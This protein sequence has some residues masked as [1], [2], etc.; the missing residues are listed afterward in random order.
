MDH[1]EKAAV[2]FLNGFNCAQSVLAAF[3]PELDIDEELALKLTSNFGGGARC[4]Q[5]CGAVSGALMVLGM[6]YGFSRSEDREQIKKAYDISVEFQK[7]FCERNKSVVC[8]ELLGY[9]ISIPEQKNAAKEKGLLKEVC[10]RMVSS[11]I[12]IIEQL[13]SEQQ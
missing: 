4:G 7:R 8:K 6:K 5:L 13:I 1:T 10:P 11:A 12:E 2:Y 3:A 9:D